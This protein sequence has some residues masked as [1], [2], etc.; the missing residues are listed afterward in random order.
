MSILGDIKYMEQLREYLKNNPT[1][2]E[3]DFK[4]EILKIPSSRGR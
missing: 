4:K 3:K 2:T 1:K